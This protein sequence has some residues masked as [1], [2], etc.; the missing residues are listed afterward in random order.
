MVEV[1]YSRSP[2]LPPG[3]GDFNFNAKL[4][5]FGLARLMDHELGPKTIM[6]VGTLA[7]MASEYISTGR[8]SKELDVFSF[9]VVALEIATGRKV[10]NRYKAQKLRT[11]FVV[12]H[13]CSNT[14]S[15]EKL[16]VEGEKAVLGG[17]S[18]NYCPKLVAWVWDLYGERKL[19]SAANERLDSRFDEQQMTCLLI[20]GL[21]CAHPDRC[22]RPSIR[23]AIQVLNFETTMPNLPSKMH[24]PSYHVPT[25]SV[26][27]GEP[28]IT[29]SSFEVGR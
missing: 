7:Y 9:R 22:F 15:V 10:I 21:W 2:E 18:K 16:G 27:Y 29:N 12:P 28:F 25:P 4:G 19:L 17:S 26:S 3:R 6:L 24:V 8:V 11:Q 5:D 23:Q 13:P 14:G 1:A 20:V